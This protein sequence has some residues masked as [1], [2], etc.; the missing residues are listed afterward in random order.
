MKVEQRHCV[1]PS[2]VIEAL[3][4][5]WRSPPQIRVRM[6]PPPVSSAEVTAALESL[7]NSGLID[8]H[9]RNQGQSAW[10]R[11]ARNQTV[12]TAHGLTVSTSAT[13]YSPPAFR[14][15]RD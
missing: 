3:D 8:R 12:P 5:T 2:A 7:A 15:P 9:A 1:D 6:T 4:D 10:R 14:A 13:R 11:T